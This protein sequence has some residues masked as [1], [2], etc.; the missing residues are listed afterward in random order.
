MTR[1]FDGLCL[2]PGIYLMLSMRATLYRS[3]SGRSRNR[4]STPRI[5]NAFVHGDWMLIF[6]RKFRSPSPAR[7]V[8]ASTNK[9]ILY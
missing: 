3:L 5:M 6:M 7:T 8:R 2:R 4:F 9:I 1:V